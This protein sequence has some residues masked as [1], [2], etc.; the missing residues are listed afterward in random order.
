MSN[1]LKQYFRKPVL[2]FKLPS[3]AKMYDSTIVNMPPNQELPVYAMT[4]ADEITMRTPD[5]LFNGAAIVDVIKSC[6]PNIL[7]PWKINS[8]DIDAIIIAIRA[9]SVGNILDVESTCP[10]CNTAGSYG[11]N[12]LTM[13]NYQHNVDYDKVLKVREL[14][15]KFRPLTYTEMNKSNLEQF[16]IQRT[17][18][19]IENYEDN[20]EK[21]KLMKST[22]DK[23]NDLVI[24][25][26]TSS[27]EYIKI[28][29][30]VVT[31]KEFIKEFLV[32]CDKKTFDSIK[33]ESVKLREFNQIK[34]TKLRCSS[35]Q[36]EYEQ[37]VVLN[38]SDF[39]V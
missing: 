27:I 7:D 21:Q 29:D 30:S 24:G 35:C 4:A 12:L 3:E 14:E 10:S 15:I 8:I 36:H 28:P 9:A 6:V 18:V 31:E 20:D 26:V 38:N 23:M 19:T 22:L 37:R 25:L 11:I 34:P 32:N 39:F 13:L 33:D 1:P 16:E 2:Y 5:A 17:L